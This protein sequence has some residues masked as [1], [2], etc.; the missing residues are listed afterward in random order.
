ME[1]RSRPRVAPAG[2]QGGAL[3][4]GR[5]S[6]A[7]TGVAHDVQEARASVSSGGADAHPTRLAAAALVDGVDIEPVGRRVGDAPGTDE[8]AAGVGGRHP[9]EPP[10]QGVLEQGQRVE[11]GPWRGLAVTDDEGRVPAGAL[12][13]RVVVAVPGVVV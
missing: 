4:V 13:F 9:A 8:L 6:V 10:A 11:P 1:G 5:L 12:L 3:D 2:G 7:A